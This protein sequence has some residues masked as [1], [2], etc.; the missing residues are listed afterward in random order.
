MALKTRNRVNASFS[1]SSMTDIVFL[2]LIFFMVTSTLIHPNALKLMLPQSSNQTKAK[3]LTTVSITSDLKYYIEDRPVGVNNLE[4]KLIEKIGNDKDVYISLHV[5][6]TVDIE[7]VVKV[8][9]I[10]KRNK[11]KMIL[12]TSKE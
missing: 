2:L 4:R 5:D 6:K 8:M 10:A 1:M 3:P 9:N 7:Y 12:A 11:F